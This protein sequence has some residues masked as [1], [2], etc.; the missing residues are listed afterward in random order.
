MNPTI[1][2]DIIE[3]N[4]K[5]KLGRISRDIRREVNNQLKFQKVLKTQTGI[6]KKETMEYIDTIN[7]KLLLL[8]MAITPEKVQ[9]ANLA[10]VSKAFRS[11]L[12]QRDAFMGNQKKEVDKNVS[13][14]FNVNDLKKEDILKLLSEKSQGEE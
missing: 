11:I 10:S 8:L 7:E 3:E 2:K 5:K 12:G 13:L 1:K 9:S 6:D 4:E 14:N